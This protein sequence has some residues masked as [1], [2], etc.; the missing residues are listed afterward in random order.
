MISVVVPS[1]NEESGIEACLKSLCDQTL[2]R[3]QYEI[4]VV[5]GNS[6]DKTREIAEKYA[7]KVFI[8]TSKKV[9]GAR[10]D[11]VLASR[12]DLI[13]TTDADCFLPRGWLETIVK[14][15]GKYPEASVIYG[16]IYPLE[17]GFK[18]KFEVFLYNLVVRFG[19]WTGVFYAT[20]GSNTAFRK[21]LFIEAGMYRV[22]DA[23]DDWELPRRMKNYGRVVLDMKMIIGFSMRRYINFGLFRS[24]FQWFY[25]VAKGGE[26]EKHQYMGKEYTKK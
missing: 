12:Y 13:V 20:L 19:A 4:I 25:V 15:F 14:D 22:V 7:D 23:G 21:N 11:G 1:F 18:H 24:A 26:S 5:D 6:K 8:Q 10:N 16:P 2:P 3:D 17:P 9:G